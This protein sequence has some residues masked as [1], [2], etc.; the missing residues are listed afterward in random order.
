MDLGTADFGG[1]AV[2]DPA[3]PPFSSVAGRIVAAVLEP[4]EGI[5]DRA[6][7]R[8]VLTIPTIPRIGKPSI[9]NRSGKS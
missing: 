5:D 4:L 1:I 2:R 6:R 9:R 7:D 8:P 3:G